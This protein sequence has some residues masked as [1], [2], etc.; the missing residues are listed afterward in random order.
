MAT[1]MHAVYP[2]FPIF[3]FSS[4]AHHIAFHCGRNLDNLFDF[5]QIQINSIQFISQILLP[6]L[7]GISAA[8]EET[9]ANLHNDNFGR[10]ADESDTGSMFA[11]E[12][13]ISVRGYWDPAVV[14]IYIRLNLNLN[15]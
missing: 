5:I 12:D 9:V 14:Y 13:C 8:A 4:V 6:L 1:G 3:E 11:I 10:G 15:F 7:I 2:T